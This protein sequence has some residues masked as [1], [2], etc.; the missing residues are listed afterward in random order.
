[1]SSGFG[2]E[3][4]AASASQP[5]AKVSRRVFLASAGLLAC[6]SLGRVGAAFENETALDRQSPALLHVGCINGAGSGSIR[7]FLLRGEQ[8]TP[9]ANTPSSPVSALALHP[10][11]PVVYVAAGS[12]SWQTLPRGALEAYTVNTETGR[13][14]LAGRFLLSLSATGPCR[15]AV[16]PNG[17]HLLI[18][19][20]AGGAWNAFS[21][22]AHGV[23]SSN[24]AIRKELGNGSKHPAQTAARP[25]TVLFVPGKGFAVG[26]DLGADRIS[27]LRPGR[28]S[29][30]VVA[31]YS[32][33]RSSG[34]AHMA[35]AADG[36]RLL[37]A[38]LLDPSLM[39]WHLHPGIDEAP[40]LRPA[41]MV[42]TGS[43]VDAIVAHADANLATTIRT[44]GE[45]SL[46]ET[47]EIG[48]ESITRVDARSAPFRGA[49][50]LLSHGGFLWVAT[51]EGLAR[52]PLPPAAN[53]GCG[54][55]FRNLPGAQ[56][57]L[58]QN[59]ATV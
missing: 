29:I 52:L 24:P 10:W 21:L 54:A 14:S 25:H 7:T 43:A 56:A 50:S 1:M 51:P 39:L 17:A 40:A 18:A 3:D 4:P 59:M 16:D 38:N 11:L 19:A 22:D 28:I 41:A 23:P 53:K 6:T 9:L 49:H 5:S 8:C 27:L 45:G 57:L 44:C 33:P 12:A 37:M 15:L 46:L 58:L 13:L 20:C 47:W 35:L 42:S 32:L 26:S 48:E 2:I 30:D 34:P 55:S 31:R 36:R